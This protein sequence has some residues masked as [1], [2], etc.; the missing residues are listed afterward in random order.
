[1][2]DQLIVLQELFKVKESVTALMKL[3]KCCTGLKPDG[4][5]KPIF[6]HFSN[7]RFKID[8]QF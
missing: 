6:S 8:F 7:I 1:M 2:Y 3:R 4:E 5:N